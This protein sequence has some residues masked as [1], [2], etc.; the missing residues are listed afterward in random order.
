MFKIQ[1]ESGKVYNAVNRPTAVYDAHN[2]VLLKVGEYENMV[3][4]FDIVQE[5]Y[6]NQGFHDVADDI[7]LME[8]PKVQEQT[9]PRPRI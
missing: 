7:C 9:C 5:T 4:Y 2:S 6:R 3:H 8:L 1:D